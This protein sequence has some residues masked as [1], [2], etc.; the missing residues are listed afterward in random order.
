MSGSALPTPIFSRFSSIDDG[1][2]SVSESS[3]YSRSLRAEM[4]KVRSASE[5][6]AGVAKVMG[7]TSGERGFFAVQWPPSP[8][9]RVQ[10]QPLGLAPTGQFN[11]APY[12]MP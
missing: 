1:T 4:V 5:P 11:A 7:N 3:S 12:L 10:V 6:P 2:L 9:A 8:A